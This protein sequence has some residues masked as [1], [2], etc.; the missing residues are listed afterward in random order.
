MS[1]LPVRLPTVDIQWLEQHLADA[2]VRLVDVRCRESAFVPGAVALEAGGPDDALE[3]AATMSRAGVGNDHLVVVYDEG[4]GLRAARFAER[5]MR[6]GH[7][8]VFVLEGGV[9]AWLRHGG[10]TDAQPGRHAPA[11][12][13]IRLS[14]P[15]VPRR[16][17]APRTWQRPA[18]VLHGSRRHRRA[19]ARDSRP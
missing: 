2:Q 3:L 18:V 19:S 11:P 10:P 5:L 15:P 17:A 8:A 16:A 6:Y 12:F 14:S 1:Q 4:R 9:S 7:P 13:T